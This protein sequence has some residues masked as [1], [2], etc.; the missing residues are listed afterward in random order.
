[1]T[2]G[3]DRIHGHPSVS[4]GPQAATR[5]TS[6]VLAQFLGH[7][8]TPFGAHFAQEIHDSFSIELLVALVWTAAV[9]TRT[10]IS[11]PAATRTTI[12]R[13]ARWS[14]NVKKPRML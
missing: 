2:L 8:C 9:V 7:G 5:I 12:S 11:R 13:T 1:M 6:K 4:G 3:T 14:H 10:T